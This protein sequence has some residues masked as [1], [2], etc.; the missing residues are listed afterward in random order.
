MARCRPKHVSLGVSHKTCKLSY[1]SD[2]EKI[3]QIAVWDGENREKS[4]VSLG[5]DYEYCSHP[6]GTIK[7]TSQVSHV[8]LET[9]ELLIDD[10]ESLSSRLERWSLQVFARELLPDSR[11]R[12][13]FRYRIP[14]VDSRIYRR[15]GHSPIAYWAGLQVCGSVWHCPVCAAKIAERR[16]L[17][18]IAALSQ[19]R[20]CGGG[21]M[22]LTLTVPHTRERKA[23]DT[24]SKLLSAYRKFGAGRF[25]WTS[26]ILGYVGSIRALEV[27]HG[28]NGWHPHLHVLVFTDSSVCDLA[29]LQT[30]LFQY[31]E[32]VCNRVG[33]TNL[34]ASHALRLDDGSKAGQYA[35]KWGYSE[36]L[37]R[38]HV[39]VGRSGSRTPWD[40]L[41]DYAAGDS[42]A[43]ILF[44]EFAEAFKGRNQLVW[45]RGLKRRFDLTEFTDKQLAVEKT[46]ADDEL[47]YTLNALEMWL[48]RRE[49]LQG[50]ALQFAR[51]GDVQGFR[52]LLRSV[53]APR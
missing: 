27:T 34:S 28:R 29:T 31:W 33:L 13:C 48:V 51:V 1:R 50:I 7:N 42:D 25:P 49:D 4:S 32:R 41:R 9:G 21:V 10:D 20:G 15:D 36:E 18:L 22:L 47:F 23:F 16:R 45:S 38:A 3:E 8:D 43:G 35:T 44:T 11:L 17:E 5:K 14:N 53:T 52:D 24:M 40:L 39:K 26:Q 37:T 46:E 30:R 6:S 12:V 19:H 2:F